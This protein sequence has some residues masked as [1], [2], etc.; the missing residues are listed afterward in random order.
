MLKWRAERKGC[1]GERIRTHS[2]ALQVSGII[3]TLQ[4]AGFEAYAVGGCVRDSLLGRV[5]TIGILPLPRNRNRLRRSFRAPWIPELP[6][7][8]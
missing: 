8:P 3:K 2:A 5:P 4:E 6:T 7:A 1:Y